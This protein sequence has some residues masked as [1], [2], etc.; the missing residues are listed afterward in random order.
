MFRIAQLRFSLA[1][2]LTLAALL[3][4]RSIAQDA[5]PSDDPSET[6]LGDVARNLRKQNLPPEN[7]I[8]DDN[9]SQ[10]IAQANN[11][12][13][14]TSLLTFLM[15]RDQKNFQVS[16]PD[17]TCSLSFTA[18]TKAL[19]SQQYA[20]MDLP[21][22]EMFKLTG[23]ATIEGD[24]LAVS[25]FNGTDWHLSEIDVA[26]TA[27]KKA[28]PAESTSPDTLA[29]APNLPAPA[30]Q[31]PQ[32]D[33]DLNAVR[34]E[35][36]ADRTVIYRMRAAAPPLTATTFSAPLNL[37]LAPG[38][39]WYWAI[40]EAKGYPPQ[41]QEKTPAADAQV[42]SPTPAPSSDQQIPLSASPQ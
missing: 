33:S 24:A 20:Q 8:D 18:A 9:L 31:I 19:L 23:P 34:P 21:P 27:V 13:P 26:F 32:F 10:V 36:K 17:V 15:G 14:A 28:A 7:V 6:P 35:K 42:V 3:P 41:N 1:L 11:Q 38:Q 22:S 16:A 12:H 29:S 39:E 5:T 30:A 2:L 4:A 25:L 37:D 40:V